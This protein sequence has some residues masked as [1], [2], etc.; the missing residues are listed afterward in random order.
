[1]A[2]SKTAAGVGI[3]FLVFFCLAGAGGTTTVKEITATVDMTLPQLF[4]SL[5]SASIL[6]LPLSVVAMVLAIVAYLGKRRN[7]GFAFSVISKSHVFYLYYNKFISPILPRKR[8]FFKHPPS[9][10][11]G[12]IV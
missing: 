12:E 9:R 6:L 3:L 10:R 4:F 8:A 7:V 11:K 2:R 1:M 5:S